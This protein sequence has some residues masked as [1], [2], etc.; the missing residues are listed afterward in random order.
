M[1]NATATFFAPIDPLDGSPH[2][3]TLCGRE[4]GLQPVRGVAEVVDAVL[5]APLPDGLL[6]DPSALGQS[7]R[8]L[9]ARLDRRADLRHRRLLLVT[10]DQHVRPSSRTS[11]RTRLAMKGEERR[12]CM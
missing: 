3:R 7:P 8:R 1:R 5:L 2:A 9:G 11:L 10:R 12:V 4:L 6:G